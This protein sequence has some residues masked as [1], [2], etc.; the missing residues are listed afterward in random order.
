[1]AVSADEQTI[2]IS[3]VEGAAV[4]VVDRGSLTVRFRP[5][6]GRPR[7]LVL[8]QDGRLLIVANEAGWVDLMPV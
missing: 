8:S 1:M 2:Y 6:G 4:A 5:T 7:G 3:Q